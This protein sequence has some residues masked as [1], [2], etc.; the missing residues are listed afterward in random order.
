VKI[1]LTDADRELYGGPEW[2][3]WDP[4]RL[5]VAEAEVLQ[6]HL[7]VDFNAYRGTWLREAGVAAIKWAAW[8]G[9]RRAGVTVAWEVFDPDVIGFQIQ[10][11]P[12]PEPAAKPAGKARGRS[13]RQ[14]R[15]DSGESSSPQT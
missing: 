9:L 1:R 8:V 4:D 13:T 3:E 10:A 15:S 14:R 7:G 6:E 2:I 11:D 12:E 5:T